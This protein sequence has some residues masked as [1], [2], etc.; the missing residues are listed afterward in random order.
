MRKP[1]YHSA[2]GT[3]QWGFSGRLSGFQGIPCL[4]AVFVLAPIV[5]GYMRSLERWRSPGLSL[6][7]DGAGLSSVG[8]DTQAGIAIMGN[9]CCLFLTAHR[10]W[11]EERQDSLIRSLPEKQ[12]RS[13]SFFPSTSG[14][15]NRLL[16]LYLYHYHHHHFAITLSV[17]S[18][19]WQVEPVIPT[20]STL[21]CW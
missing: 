15:V 11:N 19:L 20:Y 21:L 4:Q 5:Q 16:Y 13:Q 1:G 18:T 17:K 9:C 6:L 8:A 14:T 7:A 12:Q 3:P 10:K 2:H